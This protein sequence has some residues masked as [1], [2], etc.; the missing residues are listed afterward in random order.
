MEKKVQ[1]TKRIER[2]GVREK[3]VVGV[4]TTTA[5]DEVA[6]VGENL[7]AK[8]MELIAVKETSLQTVASEPVVEGPG[9]ILWK[10]GQQKIGL[11]IFLK[12]KFSLPR[13]FHQRI[14]SHLEKALIW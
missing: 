13:L 12:Q 6:T 7:E 3:R 8:R 1:K 4:E 9:R 14:M 5:K 10:I 11:K 2:R